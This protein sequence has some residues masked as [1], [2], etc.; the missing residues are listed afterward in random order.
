MSIEKLQLEKSKKEVEFEEH[1]S[2]AS[3]INK[4]SGLGVAVFLLFWLPFLFAGSAAAPW[5]GII[6]GAP[7]FM[8]LV[9][10]QLAMSNQTKVLSS[11]IKKLE[12]DITDRLWETM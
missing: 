2:L 1:Q 3:G 11:E 12:L 7:I 5:I 8:F 4:A 10:L 6:A 9:A